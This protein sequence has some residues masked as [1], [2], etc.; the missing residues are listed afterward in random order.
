MLK[1]YSL[2]IKAAEEEDYGTIKKKI[3]ESISDCLNEEET[4]IISEH[5]PVLANSW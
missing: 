5:E 2:E 1:S 4:Q 3:H